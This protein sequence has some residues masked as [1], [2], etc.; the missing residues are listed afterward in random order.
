M[1][2]HC[3]YFFDFTNYAYS[4]FLIERFCNSTVYDLDDLA[5]CGRIARHMIIDGLAANVC[6][7]IE[8]YYNQMAKENGGE[9]VSISVCSSS[10]AKDLPTSSFAGQKN[11]FL[12][13][14]GSSA[15]TD[16]VLECLASIFTDQ[17]TTYSVQNSF[18]HIM[19]KGASRFSS[20]FFLTLP[21]Q[22][23]TLPWILKYKE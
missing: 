1:V 12:N 16:T 7:M 11:S 2:S 19:V 3:C 20:W 22:V 17:A 8:D 23:S 18:D 10:T 15:V 21:H 4:V 13:V 9:P 5:V 6:K 14:V